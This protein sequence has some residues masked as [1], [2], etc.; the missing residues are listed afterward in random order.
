MNKF[1]IEKTK[2]KIDMYYTVRTLLPDF[3]DE[4]NP[5]TELMQEVVNAM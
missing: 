1:S 3:F 5:K 4:T 2:R